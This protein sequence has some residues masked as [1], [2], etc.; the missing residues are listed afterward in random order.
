MWGIIPAAGTGSRIQPLAFSKELLPVGSTIQGK[1]EK[2]KVVCEYLID[3]L[4]IAGVKK[5]CM[6]I[7]PE[8]SDILRYFGK[9][10]SNV[11]FNYVVQQRPEG[12]CDAI[13]TVVPLISSDEDVIIGLPDTIWFPAD[14]LC[15]LPSS[16]L[17]FLLFP[18]EHP[19]Y[20]DAVELGL[21]GYVSRIKVIESIVTSHWIWG[22]FKMPGY[23]FHKMYELWISRGRQDEYFGT[24]TN[25]YIA[26]GAH[27]SAIYGGKK[28]VDVGTITGY[29]DAMKLLTEEHID[30]SVNKS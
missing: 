10:T 20:F 19:Q 14:A 23:I 26:T 5:I 7:S 18:A 28:Y 27:V 2:P 29:R 13:F 12:L 25:A 16:E 8:K 24:L 21:D 1:I 9:G 11:H 3:R 22:A 4:V 17:S 30:Y 6:V 15:Q